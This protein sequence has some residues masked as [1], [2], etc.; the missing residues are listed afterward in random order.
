[1][2]PN[3]HTNGR[4]HGTFSGKDQ[5]L[6]IPKNTARTSNILVLLIVI[7]IASS[8]TYGHYSKYSLYD[9]SMSDVK[10]YVALYNGEPLRDIQTPFRYRVFTPY[11][12]RLVPNLPGIFLS[13]FDVTPEKLIS[14]RFGVANLLGLI[15]AA[16]FLYLILLRSGFNRYEG[17]L[18]A[19]LFLGI[20]YVNNYA[21]TA[22]VDSWAYATLSLGFYAALEG[23][24]LLLAVVMLLGMTAKETAV[25]I[26]FAIP[27]LH[28]SRKEMVNLLL[29]CAPALLLYLLVRF[30][31][32]PFEIPT[33][34]TREIL[35]VLNIH[36]FYLSKK[37]IFL[38]FDLFATYGILLPMAIYGFTLLWAGQRE[39]DEV[40]LS[41]I[42]PLIYLVPLLMG[43]A[44]GRI[45]TLAFIPII[46]L[47]LHA[48]RRVFGAVSGDP[49]E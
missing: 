9:S 26:P 44:V 42:V 16:Y 27:F 17:L 41:V 30:V 13:A 38:I 20:F 32:L 18:G 22:L 49:D 46:L 40:R 7:T 23:R 43:T 19:L 25:L 3:E 6:G 4:E 5:P 45:W 39:R 12:A 36:P 8:V 10:F 37:Y 1:M 11:L 33:H 31:V 14:Y 34:S 47:S 48:L 29:A 28:R 35:N 15:V 2:Q 21:G 24:L